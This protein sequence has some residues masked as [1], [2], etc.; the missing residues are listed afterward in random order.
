[1]FHDTLDGGFIK[2][3]FDVSRYFIGQFVLLV[4]FASQLASVARPDSDSK[5]DV[6]VSRVGLLA[7][8]NY[9]HW[10]RH[11]HFDG[12]RMDVI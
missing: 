4:T 10:R 6:T 7:W 1:L 9:S 5:L 8:R 2:P 12:S 11:C 3:D